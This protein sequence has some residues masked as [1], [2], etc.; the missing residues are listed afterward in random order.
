[1]RWRLILKEYGPEL[2]YI[3]GHKNIVADALSRIDMEL[4]NLAEMLC[5]MDIDDA[6][7]FKDKT[8]QEMFYQFQIA[9]NLEEEVIPECAIALAYLHEQQIK[10]KDVKQLLKD[11][12]RYHSKTF[13]GAGKDYE[14]TCRENRKVIPQNLQ[15]NVIEWY[16]KTLLHSGRDRTHMTISQHLY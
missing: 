13:H 8:S 6:P 4:G 3:Q 14:M 10:D 2:G 7:K 15:R 16:H 12:E 11:K 5:I 9:N 1:M